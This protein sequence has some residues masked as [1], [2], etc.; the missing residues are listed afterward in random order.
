MPPLSSGLSRHDPSFCLPP[1]QKSPDSRS[2]IGHVSLGS[3]RHT[4]VIS[5]IHLCE[6]EPSTGEWMRY[7]Q[8]PC[9]PDAEIGRML[10]ALCERIVP[11][12]MTLVL[13]GDIFDFDAP[14]V[15]E[16]VSQFHDLPRTAEHSVPAMAAILDDHPLFVEALARVLSRGHEIV[17]VSGNH[18]A[19]LTLP[20]V[21]T[22][23]TARLIN[24][25]LTYTPPLDLRHTLQVRILFRAWF[26][27]TAE[28]ILVE[29]GH[30][31]D[32]YCAFRYPMEPY[33]NHGREIAPTI[34]SIGTRVLV[35]RL[36]YF[37]PHVDRS[38]NLTKAGYLRH[39]V[40]YYLFTHHSVLSLWLTGLW[41]IVRRIV[42]AQ[43]RP[44]RMR[45]RSNIRACVCE[46]GARL[47]AIA[48]HARLLEPPADDPYG[49]ARDLWA[50]RVLV[51]LS[52]LAL[53]VLL[54][55]TQGLP[56][57]VLW[58][59]LP[60]VIFPVY[61]HFAPKPRLAESWERVTNVMHRL[62][63]VHR[64]RAVVFGHTHHPFGAWSEGVFYGNSGSWSAA[65]STETGELLVHER[66]L[67][68]LRTND[69]G[70][71][72]GG[73]YA[74]TNGMF[75][76]RAVRGVRPPE[77]IEVFVSPDQTTSALTD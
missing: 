77:P 11:D 30:L 15:V 23:I 40:R 34:G 24:I 42:R 50:D 4:V 56:W 36:G 37:N 10:D 73:L 29:H 49:I 22:L 46:T 55:S 6:V 33:L 52:S 20:E 48:R 70:E 53:G 61:N 45:A 28:G 17:F 2:I 62:A 65:V 32:P 9:L 68:W 71:I 54:A 14:R 18:D 19:A 58:L 51:I 59:V 41:S 27:L 74:W 38:F 7:R 67:V 47:S 39:W 25:A 26:H 12:F 69:D 75:E 13:D 57:S 5:D 66:P 43:Q 3:M 16:G 64:A 76:E 63:R 35:A 1:L 72:D 8:R 21:R 60:L 44:N 31:Y